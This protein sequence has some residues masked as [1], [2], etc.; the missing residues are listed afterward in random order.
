MERFHVWNLL[1]WGDRPPSPPDAGDV[2]VYGLDR[3]ARGQGDTRTAW[4]TLARIHSH[5]HDA[6]HST[7]KLD[8]E[9][10]Q[11]HGGVAPKRQKE[12]VPAALDPV[13]GLGAL[14]AADE[15]AVGAVALVHVQEVVAGLH[16][17]AEDKHTAVRSRGSGRTATA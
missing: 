12:A 6:D 15:R 7:F 2:S 10:G 3:R 4:T 14:E 13:R 5:S 8:G 16:V 17:E 1:H 11:A 9:A